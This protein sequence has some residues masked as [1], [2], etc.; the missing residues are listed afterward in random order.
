LPSRRRATPRAVA[1]YP[2]TLAGPTG[3]PLVI[4][5]N[6][7]DATCNLICP[8]NAVDTH[9]APKLAEFWLGRALQN[10]DSVIVGN[11][12]VAVIDPAGDG[13]MNSDVLPVPTRTTKE[14]ADARALLLDVSQGHPRWANVAADVTNKRKPET[15]SPAA[16]TS[17]PNTRPA[18]MVL[19][20]DTRALAIYI[21]DYG[22]RPEG[23]TSKAAFELACLAGVEGLGRTRRN[24]LLKTLLGRVDKTISKV[25]YFYLT[26]E[27]LKEVEA[28]EATLAPAFMS[29]MDIVAGGGGGGFG[30][31]NA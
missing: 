27:I 19:R 11:I 25:Q 15:S 2:N 7:V 29:A 6:T 10:M 23:W 17:A 18:T 16:E 1:F 3:P 14:F 26:G 20:D 28:A 24:E 21:R 8:G 31:E 9:C 22:A 5:D 13:G 30:E 4:V 12:I